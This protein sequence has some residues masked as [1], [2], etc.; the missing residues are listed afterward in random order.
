MKGPR[1]S[2]QIN[3][4]INENRGI[5][6]ETGNSKKSSHLNIKAYTQQNWKI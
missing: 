5:N 4:I 3:K 6:T 1:G 2:I